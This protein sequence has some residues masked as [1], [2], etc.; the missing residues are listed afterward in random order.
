MLGKGQLV[1]TIL[2]SSVAGLAGLALLG[3]SGRLEA[4]GF[5]SAELLARLDRHFATQD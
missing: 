1:C 3:R 2:K 4:L 5:G